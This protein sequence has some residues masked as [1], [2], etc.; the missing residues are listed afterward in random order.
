MNDL[1]SIWIYWG[2]D[3]FTEAEELDDSIAPV[4]V[5]HQ[6]TYPNAK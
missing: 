4:A 6:S 2:E 3:D 1:K 5:Y